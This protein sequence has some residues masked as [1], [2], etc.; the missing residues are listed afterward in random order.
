MPVV[1]S[2]KS[3]T[4]KGTMASKTLVKV[5]TKREAR[6]GA[7][8]VTRTS[9]AK[10]IA[11]DAQTRATATSTKDEVTRAIRGSAKDGTT[12]A[13]ATSK[14]LAAA[15]AA[16]AVRRADEA[17]ADPTA[18][19]AM[20]VKKLL[21]SVEKKLRRKEMK[22]SLGDYIRLVQLQKELDVDAPR[23][24]KVTWVETG[25]E[26]M[27]SVNPIEPNPSSPE[28]DGKNRDRASESGE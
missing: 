13:K 24:I 10:K 4:G 2:Q 17:K 3:R 12:K 26:V 18:A 28:P 20:V 7:L 27:D 8:S 23:E 16:R 14:S 25:T 5:A 22:P 6:K 11:K 19:Q 21:K 1:G 15:R 9:A